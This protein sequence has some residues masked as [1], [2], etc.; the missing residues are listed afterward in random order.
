MTDIRAKTTDGRPSSPTQRHMTT[1]H[2]SGTVSDSVA[3]GGATRF[4][5]RL[6]FRRFPEA[7]KIQLPEAFSAG[8]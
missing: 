2:H 7:G 1:H 4:I 6:D 5:A 3:G 8:T